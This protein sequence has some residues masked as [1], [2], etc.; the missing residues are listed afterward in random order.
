MFYISSVRILQ[1]NT[2][3]FTGR[4]LKSDGTEEK[5]LNYGARKNVD[6]LITVDISSTLNIS[7]TVNIRK[8]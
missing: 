4:Q 6:T 8:Y 3:C 1:N 5:L 2:L 7:T